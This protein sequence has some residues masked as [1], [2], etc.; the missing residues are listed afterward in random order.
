VLLRPVSLP[1]QHDG[2]LH[3]VDRVVDAASG[4]LVVRME[5]P[6][7]A[8]DIASGVRCKAE[9]ESTSAGAKN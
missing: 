8:G 2:Q 1:G 3:M 4:T 9:I 6:N 5:L 7:K